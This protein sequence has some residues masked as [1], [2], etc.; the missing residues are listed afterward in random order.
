MSL[1]NSHHMFRATNYPHMNGKGADIFEPQL[2][3]I[4]WTRQIPTGRRTVPEKKNLSCTS[5]L[6]R[7]TCPELGCGGQLALIFWRRFISAQ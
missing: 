2:C 3:S 5:R 6:Q 4:D 1:L 7:H